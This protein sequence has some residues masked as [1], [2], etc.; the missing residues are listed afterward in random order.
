[1]TELGLKLH[2]ET[3]LAKHAH[4]TPSNVSL[5]RLDTHACSS[6]FSPLKLSRRVAYN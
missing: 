5:G 2:L 3:T 1:M 4:N 6:V